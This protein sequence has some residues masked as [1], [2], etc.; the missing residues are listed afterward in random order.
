VQAIHPFLADVN[1][2]IDRLAK[3]LEGQEL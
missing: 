3:T 2:A 1:D